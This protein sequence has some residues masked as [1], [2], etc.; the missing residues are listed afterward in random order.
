MANILNV[1]DNRQN[2]YMLEVLFR[3]KGHE[4]VSAV[5]GVDAMEKAG[6][7]APDL[8]ISDILMPKMDGF[9]LC[10]KWMQDDILRA[11]PF[12]FY[13]ATYTDTKDEELGLKLGAERFLIKPLAPETLLDTVEEVL[14]HHRNRRTVPSNLDT[15][16]EKQVLQLYSDRLVKKLEKKMMALEQEIKE[17]K[18]IE[19]ALHMTQFSVDEASVGILWIDPEGRFVY[20]NKAA[21]QRLEYEK[22]ELLDMNVVQI[23]PAYRRGNWV[24]HWQELQKKRVLTFESHHQ[25]RTGRTFPVEITAHYISFDDQEYNFEFIIEI[26]ERKRM[27]NQLRQSQKMEAIGTL[28]GG[29]AH[30]FNNILSAILGYTELTQLALSESGTAAGYLAEVLSAGKRAKDLVHQILTFSRQT[31]KEMQPVDVKPI[32]IEVLKLLRASLP[33]T[34]EII[35]EIKSVSTIM[36]DPTQIHQIFMNLSTN[37]AYAMRNDGG[38]LRIAVSDIELDSY[39]TAQFQD[40][41]P[42]SFVRISV[43]DSGS[44]I[45]PDKLNRIF[46]PFFTTKSQGEGT[47]MGLAVVHGIVKSCSGEITVYS[48]SDKGTTFNVFLPVIRGMEKTAD[49]KSVPL[50]GGNERILYVDDE[51]D[52]AT[53][54]RKMLEHLGY[55]VT[56]QTSATEALALFRDDKDKFDLIIT[57]LTMPKMTGLQLTERIKALT[58]GIP[59]ILVTGFLGQLSRKTAGKTGVSK[60]VMKPIVLKNIARAVREV[61]DEAGDRPKDLP[62]TGIG[63]LPES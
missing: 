12:V 51:Q 14:D 8:I 58:P 39:Y 56:V 21:C 54:G 49:D 26:T 62:G 19:E 20:A 55:T 63:D 34:I 2:L 43:S 60:L 48:E 15:T 53:I 50:P 16:E 3:A 38:V 42:G 10:R 18:R 41:K 33:A 5:N 61:L 44:G 57:D 11:V 45:T 25:S 37:A 52:L 32:A 29:I 13:T 30:D 46:D 4:V 9:T 27:E 28:A 36:A 40:L 24:R 23:D 59:I 7:N 17:R 6:Q 31:E 22:D 47:G 35:S 1:D